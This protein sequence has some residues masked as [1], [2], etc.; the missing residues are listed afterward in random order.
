M[1]DS[2]IKKSTVKD[3][4]ETAYYGEATLGELLERI[5][6]VEPEKVRPDTKGQWVQG[7]QLV[8][9]P[10]DCDPWDWDRYVAESHSEWKDYWY[11]SKCRYIVND[12]TDRTDFCPNCGADM[13]KEN[14][15]DE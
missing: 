14:S 9:I 5:D 1:S 3:V 4:L 6:D 13:R 7:E 12:D 11:C 15:N 2:Y 8:P 10:W